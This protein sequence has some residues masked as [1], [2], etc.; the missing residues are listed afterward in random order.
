[1][2]ISCYEDETTGNV[3]NSAVNGDTRHDVLDDAFY[4]D[5]MRRVSQGEY[6]YVFASPPCSTFSIS[7]F[8]QSKDKQDGGAPIVRRRGDEQRG[9]RDMPEGHGR[10]VREANELVKRTAALLMNCLLYTS[11]S[12]RDS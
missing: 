12:P 8:F 6:A 11:P 2:I 1:M 4:D 5:L 3:D 10:E 7:R 9:V